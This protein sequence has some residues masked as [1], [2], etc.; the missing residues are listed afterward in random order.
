[1]SSN[2]EQLSNEQQ[3]YEQNDYQNNEQNNEKEILNT[4]TN[5]KFQ[6]LSFSLD[7]G[8]IRTGFIASVEKPSQLKVKDIDKSI[9]I[10]LF[11]NGR[12]RETDI[13]KHIKC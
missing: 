5:G 9:S 13:L 2:E 6:E 4:K 12:L 8:D 3:N 10:D 7:N 1:M 11:V